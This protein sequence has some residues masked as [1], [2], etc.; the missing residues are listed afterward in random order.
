MVCLMFMLGFISKANSAGF[1]SLVHHWNFDEGPDWHDDPF[2]AEAKAEVAR[3]SIGS[4]DA[5]FEGMGGAHSFQEDSI[6]G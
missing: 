3:D 2:Q 6:V 5:R 1:E 4:I